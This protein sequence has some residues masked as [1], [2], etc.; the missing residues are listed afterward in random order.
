M[1]R[2]NFIDPVEFI[3][4]LN[5]RDIRYL[6]IGRQ[7]LIQYGAPLQTMDYDFYLDPDRKQLES[8]LDVARHFRMDV[9]RF[10]RERPGKL[11]LYADNMKVDVF[12]ARKYSLAEGGFL[13]FEDMYAR[14]RVFSTKDGFA[15]TV[16]CLE[17]L[18]KSKLARN[19]PKDREDL[20]YIEVLLEQLPGAPRSRTERGT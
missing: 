6:L 9:E 2:E 11:T 1:R 12:R 10:P 7:A 17:D 19:S 3:G 4:E 14:R 5:H 20:K 18:K 8:I 15:V 13:V 16:P